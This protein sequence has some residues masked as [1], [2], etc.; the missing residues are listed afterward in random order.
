MI[1]IKMKVVVKQTY[2][3][4]PIDHVGLCASTEGVQHPSIRLASFNRY[5]SL[6]LYVVLAFEHAAYLLKIRASGLVSERSSLRRN[7]SSRNGSR[8]RRCIVY[9]VKCQEIDEG[10]EGCV[11]NAVCGLLACRY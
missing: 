3:I 9:P 2:N 11:G 5:T 1:T 10:F 6:T 4:S 7:S 8:T